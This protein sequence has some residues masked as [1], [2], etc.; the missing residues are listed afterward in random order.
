MNMLN[1]FE[2]KYFFNLETFLK[3][4][5]KKNI[6]SDFENVFKTYRD[7]ICAAITA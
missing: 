6:F 7:Q 2:K 3:R 5:M 1:E 4:K